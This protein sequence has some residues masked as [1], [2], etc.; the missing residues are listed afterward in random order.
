MV[1]KNVARVLSSPSY[2]KFRSSS[3]PF[4][5]S[6]DFGPLKLSSFAVEHFLGGAINLPSLLRTW[7]VILRGAVGVV[8][9]FVGAHVRSVIDMIRPTV[10]AKH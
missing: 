6:F 10:N 8:M 5:L 9:F 3:Y 2:I 7:K 1:A 4:I